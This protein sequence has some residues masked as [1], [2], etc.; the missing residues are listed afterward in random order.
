LLLLLLLCRWPVATAADI[1]IFGRAREGPGKHVQGVLHQALG[2]LLAGERHLLARLGEAVP[3][4]RLDGAGGI[5]AGRGREGGG[6]AEG[7]E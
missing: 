6:G 2:G 3:G 1:I 4:V 7:G 5:V